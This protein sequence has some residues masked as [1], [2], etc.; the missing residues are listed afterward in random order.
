MT[1]MTDE[2]RERDEAWDGERRGRTLRWGDALDDRRWLLSENKRLRDKYAI[3][4]AWYEDCQVAEARAAQLQVE[5]NVFREK[6]KLTP[7][8]GDILD[9]RIDELETEMSNEALA[10]H[11]ACGLVNWDSALKDRDDAVAER[12]LLALRLKTA[13][14]VASSVSINAGEAIS[15]ALAVLDY[16]SKRNKT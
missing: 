8:D 4:E 5:L 11:Y 12:D 9:S 3:P 10:S 13:V 1:D 2:I 14:E 15:N 16:N 7:Y 6:D